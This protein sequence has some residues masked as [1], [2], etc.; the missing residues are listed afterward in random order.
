MNTCLHFVLF[1]LS[2]CLNI[3]I[4]RVFHTYYCISFNTIRLYLCKESSDK[5]RTCIQMCICLKYLYASCTYTIR[6]GTSDVIDA[7]IHKSF[8]VVLFM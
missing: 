5:M 2:E 3:H 4:L 8:K 6:K 7:Y 1:K